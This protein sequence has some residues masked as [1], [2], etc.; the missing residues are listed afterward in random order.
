MGPL[1]HDDGG[2]TGDYSGVAIYGSRVTSS[3]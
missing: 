1:A 3:P 2:I